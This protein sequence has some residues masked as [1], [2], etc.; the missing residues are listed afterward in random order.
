M[1]LETKNIFLIA[2][3]ITLSQMLRGAI[4]LFNFQNF[5]QPKPDS[6]VPS[7]DSKQQILHMHALD[8]HH[9]FA[10]WRVCTLLLLQNALCKRS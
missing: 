2:S 1:Q 9:E 8:L 5:A 3:F 10:K 4:L 7:K 6:Q